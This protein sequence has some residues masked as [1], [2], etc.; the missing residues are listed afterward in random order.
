MSTK[1]YLY[2]TQVLTLKCYYEIDWNSYKT[3]SENPPR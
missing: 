2:G 1:Y 3:D